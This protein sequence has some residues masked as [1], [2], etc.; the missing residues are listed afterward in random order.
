MCLNKLLYEH[1]PFLS[2]KLADINNLFPFNFLEIEKEKK[3]SN[4]LLSIFILFFSLIQNK[5]SMLK[6]GIV[7]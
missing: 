6:S 7:R 1:V 5:Y 3:N 4:F 2:S